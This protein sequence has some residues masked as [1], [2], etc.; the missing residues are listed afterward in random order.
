M[1]VSILPQT[2]SHPGCHTTLSRAPCAVHQVLVGY[3]FSVAVCP[4]PS[5]TPSLSLPPSFPSATIRLFP[6]SVRLFLFCKQVHLYHFF[7][8]S[9]CKGYHMLFLLLCLTYFTQYGALQK[10]VWSFP[11]GA[12]GKEPACQYRRHKRGEF[13]PWVRKIPWRRIWLG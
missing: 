2:P 13:H 1:H 8:D 10:F 7:L 9:T 5:Q 4:C 11:C 12:S 3:P 6:K